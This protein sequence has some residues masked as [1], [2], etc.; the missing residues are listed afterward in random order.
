MNIHLSF[1]LYHNRSSFSYYEMPGTGQYR[2]KQ[3][4]EEVRTSVE[5]F[6]SRGFVV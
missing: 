2:R 4:W 3:K 5:L 1:I 6:M